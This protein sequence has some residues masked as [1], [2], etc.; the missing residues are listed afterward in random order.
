MG[1]EIPL[2]GLRRAQPAQLVIPKEFIAAVRVDPRNNKVEASEV[3]AKMNS[4][5]QDEVMGGIP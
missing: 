5:S 1:S 4:T 2:R 3:A